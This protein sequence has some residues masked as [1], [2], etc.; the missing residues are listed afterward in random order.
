MKIGYTIWTWGLESENNF[1]TALKEIKEL[2]YSYFENFIGM[3][4]LYYDKIDEFNQIVNDNGL[5]FVAIYNYISNLD[6]DNVAK[7][8]KYLDFCKKTGAK[9]MNIQAP[10]RNGKP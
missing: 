5:E 6:E 9:I 7:A 8:E 3:A 4:D 1:I 2:G 10:S